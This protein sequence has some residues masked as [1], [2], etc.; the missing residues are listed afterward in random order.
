MSVPSQPSFKLILK[1]V[2]GDTSTSLRLSLEELE[3]FLTKRLKVDGEF[4]EVEYK[5]RHDA[6]WLNCG[7]MAPSYSIATILGIPEDRSYDECGSSLQ[8]ERDHVVHTLPSN[9]PDF[10]VDL[11]IYKAS[12]STSSIETMQ[13]HCASTGSP[14][15]IDI[16]QPILGPHADWKREPINNIAGESSLTA[17]NVVSLWW[18]DL[19]LNFGSTATLDDF[20]STQED[21]VRLFRSTLTSSHDTSPWMKS[22]EDTA[23]QPDAVIFVMAPDQHATTI[24]E[25]LRVSDVAPSWFLHARVH[26]EDIALPDVIRTSMLGPHNQSMD[27]ES[28]PPATLL[29]YK[30]LGRRTNLFDWQPMEPTSREEETFKQ[31]KESIDGCLWESFVEKR[32]DED[33]EATNNNTKESDKSIQDTSYRVVCPPYLNVYEEYRTTRIPELFARESLHVFIRDALSIPQW[34]PWP[35]SVHYKVNSTNGEATN[36]WTVFPLCHCFPADCPENLTW[37]PATRAHVPETCALLEDLVGTSHLRTAL[38][39]QLAPNSVLEAH[40]GWADLANH[41]LRL[42]IPL[43]VPKQEMGLCGTWVDGCVE[44]HI[45]GRPLLFDDSKIHRAFNYSNETRIVLIVDLARP[46]HLPIGYADGGHTEELDAF[47]QEMSMPR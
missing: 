41:V 23:H 24:M 13:D 35:E 26:M 21:V 15:T 10:S 8:L 45:V 29:I 5:P 47:I 44:T 20:L 18:I 32:N 42:H 12:T 3:L 37:I 25:E 14:T 16:S 30:R 11:T 38:F 6:H 4:E 33:E 22:S 7:T 39:S 2:H 9:T 34:T 27:E 43:V 17:S 1:N 19:R 40:T 28:S 46:S 31:Q 36:P